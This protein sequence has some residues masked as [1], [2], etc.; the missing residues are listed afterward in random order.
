MTT[1]LDHARP[2]CSYHRAVTWLPLVERS[3]PNIRAI[4]RRI[5]RDPWVIDVMLML[6]LASGA[7]FRAVR[8]GRAATNLRSVEM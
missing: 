1:L 6:A 2:A 8:A 5:E 3:A 7:R 4:F